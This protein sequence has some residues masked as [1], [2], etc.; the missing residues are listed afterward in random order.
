MGIG[1]KVWIVLRLEV[2]VIDQ[3]LVALPISKRRIAGSGADTL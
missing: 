3:A 2:K 1:S